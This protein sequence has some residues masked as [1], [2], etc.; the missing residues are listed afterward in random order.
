VVIS[1]SEM[2]GLLS[3]ITQKTD[4]LFVMYDACHSGGI[5]AAA[6]TARTRGIANGNDEGA[7]RPEV[8]GHF[9]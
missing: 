3:S 2:A 4:K 7:L 1:N 8:C 9:R 5:V 6:V